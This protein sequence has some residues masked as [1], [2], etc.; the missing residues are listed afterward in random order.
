MS[1]ANPIAAEEYQRRSWSPDREYVD[2]QVV[3]RNLGEYEHSRLQLRIGAVLYGQESGAKMKTLCER[4]VLVGK[5]R[6]RI[7]DLCVVSASQSRDQVAS[8]PPSICIEILSPDD[9]AGDLLEKVHGY[10]ANG[11]MEVWVVDPQARRAQMFD[12]SGMHAAEDLVLSS[13]QFPLKVDLKPLFHELE[14]G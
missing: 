2:G 10:L 14:I 11:V 7:P 8:A 9:R 5:S 3:E 1:A 12:S 13:T 6:Y 4:R